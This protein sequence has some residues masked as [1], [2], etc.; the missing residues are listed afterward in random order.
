[1]LCYYQV[2]WKS[3]STFKDVVEDYRKFVVCNYGNAVVVFDGYGNN[4]STKDHEHFR[5]SLKS[6]GCADIKVS[7]EK[8]I[9]VNQTRFLSNDANKMELIKL[10]TTSLETSGCTVKQAPDDADTLIVKGININY[11]SK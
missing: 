5:R 6:K 2:L 11:F 10:I 1:M 4:P 3:G 8:R 7:P 9:T